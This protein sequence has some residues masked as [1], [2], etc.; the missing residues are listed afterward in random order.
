MAKYAP[1]VT[2][3]EVSEFE[4]DVQ[5]IFAAPDGGYYVLSSQSVFGVE[6]SSGLKLIRFDSE[7]NRGDDLE[8]EVGIRRDCDLFWISRGHLYVLRG[9]K[10]A[11]RGARRTSAMADEILGSDPCADEGR[12][13]EMTIECHRLGS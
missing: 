9:G 3:V 4:R 6:A 12:F 5:R 11:F 10:S 7:G 8:A 13:A 1:G 2:E